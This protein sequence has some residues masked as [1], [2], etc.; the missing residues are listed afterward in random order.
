MHQSK[1]KFLYFD[2]YFK[3]AYPSKPLAQKP[4]GL[5]MVDLFYIIALVMQLES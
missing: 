1:H 3:Q 2:N 5:F 4:S